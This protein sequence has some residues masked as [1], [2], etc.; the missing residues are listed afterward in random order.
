MGVAED[1][2]A[3]AASGAD[4]LISEKPAI[5]GARFAAN[6][7]LVWCKLRFGHP[8]MTVAGWIASGLGYAFA[9]FLVALFLASLLTKLYTEPK[10]RKAFQT[11]LKITWTL[12][13]LLACLTFMSLEL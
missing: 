6:L 8:V 12:T 5:L 7:F 2:M 1:A 9:P 13:L 3:K 10:T 4:R 11:N